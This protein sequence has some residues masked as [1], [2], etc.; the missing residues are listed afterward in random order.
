[1]AQPVPINPQEFEFFMRSELGKDESVVSA[2]GQE[3]I[4]A[5]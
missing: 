3:W 4:K 2:V 5:F 1:M